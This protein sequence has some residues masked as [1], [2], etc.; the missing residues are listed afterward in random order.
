MV[1]QL[2]PHSS[3]RSQAHLY[4]GPHIGELEEPHHEARVGN[5]VTVKWYY[6]HWEASV[7]WLLSKDDRIGDKGQ[8]VKIDESKFGKWKYHRGHH[9]D[10]SSVSFKIELWECVYAHG[11]MHVDMHTYDNPHDTDST[12]WQVFGGIGQL[13][14]QGAF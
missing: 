1:G 5:N 9:V 6:E 14:K 13:G 11:C 2:Q 4:V 3:W 8:I 7:A 10:G 12:S